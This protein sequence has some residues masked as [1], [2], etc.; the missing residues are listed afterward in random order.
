MIYE[1]V[2]GVLAESGI[3]L[4]DHGI[5]DA[6]WGDM[7]N[8]G[9]LD[10][11]VIG[12][13]RSRLYRN[14]D[15]VLV[16]SGIALPTPV[17]RPH[18]LLDDFDTDGDLDIYAFDDDGTGT[19]TFLRN[20]RGSFADADTGNL[21]DLGA[22]RSVSG[23]LDRDGTPDIALARTSP[24]DDVY[25]RATGAF[26]S[27]NTFGY[28]DPSIDL[29]DYDDDGSLE[30]LMT[31]S[32]DGTA[33]TRTWSGGAD[34]D[35]P[36]VVNVKLG[37]AKWGDINNDGSLD[38]VISGRRQNGSVVTRMYRNTSGSFTTQASGFVPSER[39]VISLADIDSDGDLDCLRV[40]RPDSGPDTTWV[41]ENLVDTPNTPPLAPTNVTVQ[42]TGPGVLIQWTH[43]QDAE[44]GPLSYDVR[45]G[46]APG[47][48]D[49]FT[50]PADP[51]TGRRL[52]A[53]RGTYQRSSGSSVSIDLADLT[54]P[55]Y[56]S[57]QAIDAAF[58][59][60]PFSDEV[61]VV[62]PDA[63]TITWI[64][65]IP[66][67][68]GGRVS[69][70]WETN[71]SVDP[72]DTF[73]VER[74]SGSGWEPVQFIPGDPQLFRTEYDF[75]TVV[76]SPCDSTDTDPC[77]TAYRVR[78][79]HEDGTFISTQVIASSTVDLVPTLP[80]SPRRPRPSLA[81]TERQWGISLTAEDVPDDEGGR[82]RL[83]WTRASGDQ[84]GGQ[85]TKYVVTHWYELDGALYEHA[86][87]TVQ[88]DGSPT[89]TIDLDSHM[90][91]PFDA[92]YRVYALS[93]RNVWDQSETRTVRTRN[94]LP[95]DAPT[96][97]AFALDRLT[98]D[99]PPEVDFD[100]HTIYGS[101]ADSLGPEA[102][103]LG[104]A[105]EPTSEVDLA[106]YAY[107][108]VTTSDFGGNESLAAVTE[109]G[110]LSV[111]ASA[112]PS[113]LALH[114]PAP[115]PARSRTLIAVDLP[116]GSDVSLEV[117]DVRG[118]VVR[119]LVREHRDAGRHAITWDRRTDAGTLASAGVYYVRM[120][121]ST[122][123]QS[124]RLVLTARR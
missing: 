96:G 63:P 71:T 47:L 117:F 72:L 18:V 61:E 37:D 34:V 27:S 112:T 35:D 68:L 104:Y 2:N 66:F 88:A 9:D 115:N 11:V 45:I 4:A 30:L 102:V 13:T 16:N 51:I 83:A 62:H 15:G 105:I 103:V 81:A 106:G 89:Y 77:A 86:Q 75:A 7:D 20:D 23:D 1:N 78:L 95:P 76:S 124:A 120:K 19:T 70:A 64:R 108:L 6:R 74:N 122:Q 123:T 58:A 36:G 8:D 73:T 31:G 12:V 28:E 42:V 21:P 119:T 59:G 121:T 82:A 87:A 56:I 67:D 111:D 10:L 5:H 52:V 17:A 100:Y 85:V 32:D 107:A 29:G 110:L 91:R 24:F 25:V 97:L 38:M 94:N 101:P 3:A 41:Y 40:G 90:D 113:I 99:A 118:R 22:K 44:G 57:V 69:V 84:L 98:W 14:D 116:E 60:S 55:C 39:G 33:V 80:G 54:F 46:S 114:G 50:V 79:E 93:E 26:G 53:Q 65:D 49:L 43:A 109:T 48:G 92:L